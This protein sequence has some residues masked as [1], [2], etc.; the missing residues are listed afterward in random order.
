MIEDLTGTDT[1][2]QIESPPQLIPWRQKSKCERLREAVISTVLA[3]KAHVAPRGQTEQLWDN[4][5]EALFK[6]PIFERYQRCSRQNIRK[7]FE[8]ILSEVGKKHV[9]ISSDGKM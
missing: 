4:V 3:L 9:Y 6:N 5:V 8:E 2:R 7:Q 1:S